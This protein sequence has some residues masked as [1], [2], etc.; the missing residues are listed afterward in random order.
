MPDAYAALGSTPEES[1]TVEAVIG[2]VDAFARDRIDARRIDAAH[3]VDAEI[4]R[5]LAEMGLFGLSIPEEHGGFGMSLHAVGSVVAALARHDRSVATTVGLH[6]GLGTRGMVAFGSPELKARWLPDLAAGKCVAAFATTEAD[7]GSD[8]GAIRTRGVVEGDRLRVTG[9]KIYVTNGNYADVFTITASTPGLGGARRGHS[10]LFLLKDDA[11]LSIGAEEEKLGL[12]GSSTTTVNL[13][14]L[15]LPLDRVIG[16]A[17]QGMSHLQHVLAW[18]RTAMAAGCCGSASAAIDRVVPHVHVRKQF[19]KTLASFEVV[20]EQLATMAALRFAMEAIVR[21]VGAVEAD[22]AA[23]AAR[24]TS[25]KVF[26]SEGSWEVADTAVQLFGG[27]GF[28][29]ETGVALILRD[30]RITRIFEGANDVLRVHLGLMESAG[31]N[32]RVSLAALGPRGVLADA[33]HADVAALRAR[34]AERWGVRLASQQRALHRLGGLAALRDVTDAAVLRAH[35]DGSE[36]AAALADV[37]LSLARARTRPL[38]D[39]PAEL[40]PLDRVVA[41]LA[42]ELP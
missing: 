18:G 4:R 25:A 16:E 1:A 19:G 6:L 41:D 17:G 13:D 35:A 12:R 21:H 29:E 24:S 27:S 34:L 31:V 28:V 14:G 7:A 33:L 11:G 39:A 30:A 22:Y 37:W 10:L 2:S 8:L 32:P 3:T 38:L 9:S 42:A 26:C 23:L 5:D 15:D 40:D 36:G 20:R